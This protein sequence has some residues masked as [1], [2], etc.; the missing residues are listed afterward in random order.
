MPSVG[1]IDPVP[2]RI[3]VIGKDAP[4]Y[5]LIGGRGPLDLGCSLWSVAGPIPALAACVYHASVHFR[6]C[7]GTGLLQISSPSE[8]A[9]HAPSGCVVYGY[10]G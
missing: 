6:L 1:S 10:R 5:F 3:L 2:D 9:Q 7:L 8:S 4:S